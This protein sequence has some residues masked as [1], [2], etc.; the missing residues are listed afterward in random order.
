MRKLVL[1]TLAF[2]ALTTAAI[3]ATVYWKAE[4]AIHDGVRVLKRAV[5]KNFHDPESARFR[6]VQLQSYD[7]AIGERL[8]LIGATFLWRST[9]D[10]VFS[11][12]RYD[13]E[14]FHLCGEVN[15]KNG[16]GAYVGYRRFYV[17]G[18]KDPVPFID[19]RD[20]DFAKKMCDIG[21]EVLVF[22]EPDQ[23]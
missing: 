14:S 22:A 21:K 8:K 4:Q 20:D 6:A 16:F 17:R 11:V 2:L 9:P 13:P 12:F 18:G 15:A 23:K 7:G 5:T 19:N 10:K 3:A 1:L